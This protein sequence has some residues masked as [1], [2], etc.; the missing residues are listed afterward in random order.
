M[1]DNYEH[2]T[3]LIIIA[4]N[5]LKF[6]IRNLTNKELT[7]GEIIKEKRFVKIKEIIV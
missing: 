7:Y 1:S 2:S 4:G 5:R 3:Q 6:H